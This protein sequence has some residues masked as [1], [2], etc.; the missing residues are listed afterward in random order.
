MVFYMWIKLHLTTIKYILLYILLNSK[1]GNNNHANK[2]RCVLQAGSPLNLESFLDSQWL[3]ILMLVYVWFRSEIQIEKMWQN[4][5][6][7]TGTV[8]K[9]LHVTAEGV[10]AEVLKFS[11]V[12]VSSAEQ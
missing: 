6:M 2:K 9:E 8:L 11:V 7:G 3:W 10:M 12:H 4:Y 1:M 5:E